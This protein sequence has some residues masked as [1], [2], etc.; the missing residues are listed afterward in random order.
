M[1]RAPTDAVLKTWRLRFSANCLRS[2]VVAGDLV[3]AWNGGAK[4]IENVSCA[5]RILVAGCIIGCIAD[6]RTAFLAPAVRDT[7]AQR[8]SS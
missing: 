2:R 1:L 6:F 5:S 7:C 3:P 4:I 8:T